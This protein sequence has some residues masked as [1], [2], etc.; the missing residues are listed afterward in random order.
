MSGRFTND[1]F[2]K[3][4][5]VHT[6]VLGAGENDKANFSAGD[7]LEGEANPDTTASDSAMLRRLT[8]LTQCGGLGR[9]AY[10]FR[11]PATSCVNRLSTQ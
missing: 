11:S 6:G 4:E 8:V 9:R 7:Q 10:R 3:G 2:E 1:T 5:Y